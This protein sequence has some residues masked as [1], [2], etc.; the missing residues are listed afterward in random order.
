MEQRSVDKS[1]DGPFRTAIVRS[2]ERRVFFKRIP[3]PGQHPMFRAVLL[4]MPSLRLEPRSHEPEVFL[5]PVGA[6]R[7]MMHEGWISCCRTVRGRQIWA[8]EIKVA[9]MG[10]APRRSGR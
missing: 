8:A 5:D 4:I 3:T 6:V 7:H 9:K 10:F 2:V 1:Q